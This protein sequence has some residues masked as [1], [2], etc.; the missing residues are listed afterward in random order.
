VFSGAEGTRNALNRGAERPL[1]A[2]VSHDSPAESTCRAPSGPPELP[3]PGI[4]PL[5]APKAIVVSGA[6]DHDP[7]SPSPGL[8]PLVVSSADRFVV[9]DAG[10]LVVSDADPSSDPASPES[11][12][13]VQ[14]NLR[15]FGVVTGAAPSVV[16]GAVDSCLRMQKHVVSKAPRT[17]NPLI[18]RRHLPHFFALT[19]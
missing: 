15:G 19:A 14:P 1:T 5:R 18:S 16:S 10:P 11:W 6:V 4:S 2:F 9:S 7:R 3:N 13:R 17:S 8:P 12:F